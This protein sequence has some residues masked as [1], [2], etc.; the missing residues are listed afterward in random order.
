LAGFFAKKEF[1]LGRSA[2]LCGMPLAP[3]MDFVASH[4]VS[5]LRTGFEELEEERKSVERLGARKLS[6]ILPR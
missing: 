3:F 2:E 5:P 4:G 1:R 6:P